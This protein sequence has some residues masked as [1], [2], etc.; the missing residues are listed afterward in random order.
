[1][2]R[3]EPHP[4]ESPTVYRERQIRK[5]TRLAVGMTASTFMRTADQQVDLLKVI[6][7]WVDQWSNKSPGPRLRYGHGL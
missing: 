1:M 2:E 5:S 4:G 6:D 3:N 7:H